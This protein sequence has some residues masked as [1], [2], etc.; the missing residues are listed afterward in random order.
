MIDATKHVISGNKLSADEL[1]ELLTI[2]RLKLEDAF[3]QRDE[4]RK[5][6]HN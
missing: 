1:N 5:E 3:A 2:Y 4:M 6:G